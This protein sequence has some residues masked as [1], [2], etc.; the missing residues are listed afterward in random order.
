MSSLELGVIGNCAFGALVDDSG[1]IVWCCLPRF[2]GDPV[3]C[4]LLNNSRAIEKGA[5]GVY[6]IELVDLDR[7]EQHYVK[8]T[9]VLV[10]RLY[11]K[12]GAAVEIM[13]FAPRFA[14][15][16]R[17]FRPTMIVRRVK[18]LAGVPQ[19][20]VVLRPAYGYGAGT[21]EVTHGSNHIRFVGPAVTLRLTTDAPLAYLLDETPFFLEEPITLILGPDETL[22]GRVSDTGRGFREKTI[23]YWR[24]WTRTLA[25]PLEWQDAVIRA[26][27]TLKLCSFEETG[28]IVAAMT[29][30]IPES[31][32]SGRNWDYRF[33][34]LRDAFFV[35]RA[36]NRLGAVT[37]LEN[38][39]RYLTNIVG[40]AE[41]GY[42]QPVY[43]IS[44]E[45][46]LAEREVDTLPGYRGMGPVRVGN[47]AH[48]H[49]QHDVYGH[50][51]LAATQAF[52]DERLLRP[53]GIDTFRRL[54]ANGERAFELHDK[55]DAGL[56]E[57][58]QRKRVH[59][60]SM[61]MCWAAC[62]RLAK[63]AAHLGLPARVGYWQGRANTVR[64]AIM[65]RAW[66]PEINAF[67]EG[68]GSNDVDA[69]LL[70]M[71][72]VGFLRPDDPRFTGTLAVVEQRLRCGNH[73][74]RYATA[75][76]FGP[77]KNAFTICTFWFIESLAAVG[78]REEAR[79]MF[80]S[81]LACRNRLG[82]L[83]ED[84]DPASNELWGNF[85]QTYSLVGLIHC[86]RKLSHRWEEVL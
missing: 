41:G 26:A 43:G 37:T 17:K 1:G 76:D 50:V 52:F 38:Y 31:A 8:N 9:A 55:P 60:S 32:A 73:M 46:R 59:T 51:V 11:D 14:Q 10:T 42:L 79:E 27:I 40:A 30:S 57:L 75:D 12:N 24:D 36:L 66:N 2:D 4:Q 62:D 49:S 86:A 56:W 70:L 74:F 23:D 18:P 33:C 16:G 54:E 19:V 5:R 35:V 72:E 20:R 44:L 7:G 15:F 64:A 6:R 58:R 61:L 82:L 80:E 45:R 29:T 81:V 39:L 68:A 84:I 78:R 65:K 28:G 63:I 53:A 71:A 13:D 48:E 34:W 69:S 67:A 22:T 83:S 47:Q 3:F 21:P 77:P 25:L 85:P